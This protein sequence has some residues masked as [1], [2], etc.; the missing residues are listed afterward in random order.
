MAVIGKKHKH[1]Y[2]QNTGR[3]AIQIPAGCGFIKPQ[4]VTRLKAQLFGTIRAKVPS[5]QKNYRIKK[6][7][8]LLHLC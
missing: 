1:Q 3:I 4:L 6:R 5:E 7:R 8:H 2:I